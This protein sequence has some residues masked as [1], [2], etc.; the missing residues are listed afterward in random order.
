M[1]PCLGL[2]LL[3]ENL[4]PEPCLKNTGLGLRC[5]AL[6]DPD[7]QQDA[8][9]SRANAAA[10]PKP[11]R[12]GAL[13]WGGL[14]PGPWP[15]LGPGGPWPGGPLARGALGP[16]GPWPGGPLARG[17]LGP[18]GPLGRRPENPVKKPQ[19]TKLSNEP[20]STLASWSR[21]PATRDQGALG[22]GGRQ[23]LNPKP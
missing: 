22:G 6:R 10:S 16:G 20:A 19:I 5:L 23:T 1:A 3:A 15:G 4:L 9:S 12:F 17:A 8:A 11:K 7:H 2:D 13:A 14:G 18:G 21:N